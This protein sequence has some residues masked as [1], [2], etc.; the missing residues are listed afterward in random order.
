M[1][2]TAPV[3][4]FSLFVPGLC[5]RKNV[6]R[7]INPVPE[8]EVL[9]VPEDDAEIN[10]RAPSVAVVVRHAMDSYLIDPKRTACAV[11]TRPGDGYEIEEA[12]SASK[13]YDGPIGE[14]CGSGNAPEN[15]DVLQVHT[16]N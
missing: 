16:Q 2:C 15:G 12:S 14:K 9:N 3:R 4:A 7:T 1:N 8:N 6:K 10:A 5:C 13:R 11:I